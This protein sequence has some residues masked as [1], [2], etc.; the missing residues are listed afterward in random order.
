MISNWVAVHRQ[1]SQNSF[2]M[3]GALVGAKS[4][5]PKGSQSY[6]VVTGKAKQSWYLHHYELKKGVTKW[7]MG[8]NGWVTSLGICNVY[9][10][11][12]IHMPALQLYSG[13]HES[14]WALMDS[15]HSM[16]NF[17][18][19]CFVFLGRLICM[20]SEHNCSNTNRKVKINTYM[21]PRL[22]IM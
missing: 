1:L 7:Q 18:F 17:V 14:R 3:D 22:R 20:L 8:Q 2:P 16:D 10:I 12:T 15:M 6:W 13:F 11:D 21:Q 4:P 5:N 9:G 19:F